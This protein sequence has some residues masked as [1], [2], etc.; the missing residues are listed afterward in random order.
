MWKLFYG[1]FWRVRVFTFDILYVNIY[2]STH[3]YFHVGISNEFI[4]DFRKLH[5][6]IG[7]INIIIHT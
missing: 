5:L 4:D 7:G 1:W 2:V 3:G 6:Y